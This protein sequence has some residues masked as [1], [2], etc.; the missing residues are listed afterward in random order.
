[1]QT[2]VS[3]RRSQAHAQR[4]AEAGDEDDTP[5]EYETLGTLYV[6]ANP[7]LP[8]PRMLPPRPRRDRPPSLPRRRPRARAPGRST[9]LPSQPFFLA[10]RTPPRTC[11]C[12]RPAFFTPLEPAPTS[13]VKVWP[14][15][16]GSWS[17]QFLSFSLPSLRST[18]K[19]SRFSVAP[20][21]S[22][23]GAGALSVATVAARRRHRAAAARPAPKGSSRPLSASLAAN[24]GDASLFGRVRTCARVDR[25]GALGSFRRVR[26]P[27]RHFLR[28]SDLGISNAVSRKP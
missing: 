9:E 2:A 27:S 4:G 7:C 23:L 20:P 16:G 15:P 14:R 11:S 24:A 26:F 3:P 13:A 28:G 6:R 18:I 19:A 21:A 5:E 25:T 17:R 10:V 1:M 22:A 8:C 12:A